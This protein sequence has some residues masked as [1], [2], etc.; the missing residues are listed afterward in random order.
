MSELAPIADL[1]GV[2]LCGGES[3]RMGQPKEW[4]LLGE[5]PLLTRVCRLLSNCVD[6]LVVVA[7]P[8]Q[9]LPPLPAQVRILRDPQPQAGPLAAVAAGL[10]HLQGNVSA[11]FVTACDMPFPQR[12]VI[13]HLFA[14]LT[15]YAVV[16]PVADGYH[17]P[18]MAVYRTDLAETFA[19]MA[20]HGEKSLWRA[21]RTVAGD[22]TPPAEGWGI[23][24]VSVAEICQHDPELRSLLNINTPRDW[25][26]IQQMFHP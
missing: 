13:S 26:H 15:R 8:G 20:Q 9:R 21:L 23:K 6:P 12:G 11:A 22:G 3:T 5:E 2:V 7:A 1:G 24:H 17:Q 10:K 19:G 14:K 25:E 4:L 18:L 16:V